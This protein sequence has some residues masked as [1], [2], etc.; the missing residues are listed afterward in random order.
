MNDKKEGNPGSSDNQDSPESDRD[1]PSPAP[2]LTETEGLAGD[3]THLEMPTASTDMFGPEETDSFEQ[4]K[5]EKDSRIG[6]II[7]PYHIISVAGTGGFG[8]V[9]KA[10]DVKLERYAA[11]KFL[12]SMR[13]DDHR[14]RFLREAKTIA[15]LSR[16]PSIVQIYSQDEHEG[17]YY[18]ALEYLDCSATD[19]L[20]RSPKGLPV[21]EALKIIADC[22]EGLAY[23]HAAGVFHRDIKPGNILIDENAGRAK[24]CDFGL[25]QF[26][27]FDPEG[28]SQTIAGS[29]PYMSPEQASGMELDER[30]DIY[31]LG[32]TLF[33]LL[34]G[35]LPFRRKSHLETLHLVQHGK[36]EPLSKFRPD[37]P[38]PVLKLVKK[39]TARRPENRFQ[40]AKDF[41]AAVVNLM[42]E[43]SRTGAASPPRPRL[44]EVSSRV[45]LAG[46]LVAITA[47]LLVAFDVI[48]LRSRLE[49]PV[50]LAE[51][52]QHLDNGDYHN[53]KESYEAYL[54]ERPDDAQASYGLGYALLFL[55]DWAGA[56]AQFKEISDTPLGVEG[57]AALAHAERGEES[58]P[59]LEHAAQSVPNR[60]VVVLL[61]SLDVLGGDFEGAVARLKGLE[62]SRFNFIWQR[63]QYSSVL[64]QAYYKLGDFE[65]AQEIL[66]NIRQTSGAAN[67][68][69]AAVYAQMARQQQLNAER[70]LAVSSQIRRLRAMMDAETPDEEEFDPWTSRPIRV[71]LPPADPGSS[72]QAAESGLADVFPWM[73]GEALIRDESMPIGV[74]DRDLIGNV[75]FE[76][77]LAQLSQNS[78]SVKL[79]QVRGARL[80]VQT[81]FRRLFKKDSVWLRIIDTETTN[82]VPMEKQPLERTVD[83]E[84]WVAGIADQIRNTVL[85]T[86]PLRGRLRVDSEGPRINIGRDVGVKVGRTFSI[87]SGPDPGESI[88]DA[89]ATVSG[90]I[91]ADGASVDLAGISANSVPGDGLYVQIIVLEK[92][93]DG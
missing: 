16:H 38:E 85:K 15:N 48:G 73:L 59:L 53:A 17:A 26:Q 75:L 31:S 55:G 36:G 89:I 35:Q 86:F 12:H 52:K 34:S 45:I 72:R 41:G 64:G 83:P 10:R 81:E 61:A 29:P 66:A 40:S 11:I 13:K 78:D 21:L 49:I 58:R 1:K 60:Y 7:G 2:D 63:D 68:Q 50:A 87:L 92:A 51:A 80:L 70:Q 74:V 44:R 62:Q 46:G 42:E 71:W 39:A 69:I 28:D 25:A 37:L 77:E 65:S 27:R 57:E 76:Q 91:T 23:A 5:A 79:G 9:Y 54:T 90:N 6:K 4:S 93:A 30:S 47:L 32:V 56:G 3:T 82:L 22:C 14:K 20:V 88:P 19:L 84:A 43:L 24:L 67:A 18:F 8:T 33:K